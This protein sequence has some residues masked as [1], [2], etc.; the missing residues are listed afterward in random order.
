VYVLCPNT[1]AGLCPPGLPHSVDEAAYGAGAAN[2][3][4]RLDDNK[5]GFGEDRSR[6]R[7]V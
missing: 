3:R 6:E 7:I 4:H 1:I 5:K 2:Y